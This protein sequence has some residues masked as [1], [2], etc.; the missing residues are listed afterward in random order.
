M[1]SAVGLSTV[2]TPTN[3]PDIFPAELCS[4]MEASVDPSPIQQINL[5]SFII[6]ATLLN[7]NSEIAFINDFAAVMLR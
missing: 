2:L 1:F 5:A 3:E 7:S 6:F 4:L